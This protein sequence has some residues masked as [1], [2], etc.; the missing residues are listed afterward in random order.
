MSAKPIVDRLEGQY[1]R[2]VR[3]VRVDLMTPAGRDLALRYQFTFTPFFTGL[4]SRGSV[5]W[6]QS[7]RV[8]TAAMF[9]QLLQ[10]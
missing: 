4:D 2:R 1:A 5:V 10:P 3:V 9:E 8:P 7:G 6:Q